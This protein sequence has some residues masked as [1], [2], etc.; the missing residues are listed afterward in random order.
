[1]SNCSLYLLLIIYY[2]FM[3]TLGIKFEVAGVKEAQAGLTSLKNSLNQ[4]LAQN[5][6]AVDKS[7]K[8]A[9]G[10]VTTKS[11]ATKR[12]SNP[13]PIPSER[14]EV[15]YDYVQNY[16]RTLAY[17]KNKQYGAATDSFLR[18]RFNAVAGGYF[19]GIGSAGANRTF[20]SLENVLR[21]L[22]GKEEYA[23]TIKLADETINKLN[24]FEQQNQSA[25]P[26]FKKQTQ[27]DINAGVK[28]KLAGSG[29]LSTIFD[30]IKIPIKTLQYSFYEGI[31]SNFGNRFAEGL[32]KAFNEDLDLSF[33]RKG[34]VSGKAIS[35]TATSGLD[36]FNQNA[37]QVGD[38]YNNLRYAVEDGQIVEVG[39]KF[40]TLFKSIVKSVTGIGDSYV[41]GFRKSSVQLEA[42]R[43]IEAQIQ[44]E[45][46]SAGDLTGKTKVIY[47]VGGFAADKGQ[48]GKKIA[49]DLK[50]LVN[51]Q[52]E[53][54][55]ADNA[56][57]D[58]TASAENNQ[59]LWGLNALANTT[60]INL[61]GFNPDA[62]KLAAKVIN[63]LA[64]NPKIK[65]DLV[66]HSAGGFVVEEAQ[67]ILNL[68][69]KGD[70]VKA[71]TVGTPNVKGGIQADG[72]TRIMGEKDP[73]LEVEKAGEHLGITDNTSVVAKGVKNHQ[74][75][76]YLKSDDFVQQ[77]LG[78]SLDK[79]KLKAQKK[80][81][82]PFKGKLIELESLHTKY[83]S[84]IYQ[85]LDELGDELSI[86]PDRLIAKNR[87]AKLRDRGG[88]E[89]NRKL[90]DG[91]FKP[92]NLKE[93]TETAVLVTG[94][95]SGAK[96]RSGAKF[97]K[98]LN[99]LV[100]DGGKTQYVGV[101][102]PFTDVLDAEDVRNPD[103][104]KSMP[105]ILDM[106]AQ[107][108]ELGYNPDA[109]EIA[110]Q[111]MD[112][113]AKN[114]QLKV[115]VAG[116]SGGGYVAEDV[117]ELLKS[118]GADMKR[119][120]VMGVG[121][122]QLPG[123]VKNK[124][125]RKVMGKQ[126]PV[127]MARQLKQLNNKVKE[128]IGFD[129][130]PELMTKLQNIEGIDTHDLDAYVANSK[131][132]QDFFY[133]H[134][135]DS[136]ELID[137]YAE[138]NLLKNQTNDVSQAMGGISEDDTLDS[139]QKLEKLHN[140]K[141]QYINLLR[142]IHT[143]AKYSQGIG[144]G[145][146]F[147]TEREVSALELEDA[148]VIVDPIR[149]SVNNE[150]QND[151]WKNADAEESKVINNRSK[152]LAQEYKQY[153][154]SLSKKTTSDRNI[155]SQ[156]VARDFASSDPS[157]QK[158]L[159]T[160][161]KQNFSAKAK[162]YRAAVKSGQLELAK[163]Q[164]EELI[165]LAA[166]IKSL[167]GELSQFDQL[168][169]EIQSNF[170]AY[171]SY[172]GSVE[173]EVL[174]GGGG[175]GRINQGLPDLFEQQLNL[176]AEDGEN[177][178]LGFIDGILD[179]LM[180]ARQAGEQLID[181]VEEGIRDA[182]EIQSP[183]KLAKRLG[184]WFAQ[185]FGLGL[186]AEDLEA[187]GREVVRQAATGIEGE[188]LIEL[189][190]PVNLENQN[191][192]NKI[193]SGLAGLIAK[194]PILD[195]Y[196]NQ[197]ATIAG[198]LLGGLGIA[199][200]VRSLGQFGRQSLDTAMAV[201]SLN[202]AIMF[203]S[204]DFAT[205]ADN[206]NYVSQTAKELSIDLNA[207]KQ[208]YAGLLGAAKGTPLE[209]AQTERIFAAFA[210]TAANRGV[211]AQGQ[212]R[213]FTAL[214]Q[215][216]GKRKLQAEEV[217][218]QIGDIKGFGDFQNL[219]AQALGVSTPQLTIMMEQG[220]VGIDVLPKIAALLEAQNAAADGTQTALQAQ[221]KY[222]NSLIEFQTALGKLLQPLQKLSFNV[223]SQGLDFLT[224]K[225]GGLSKI[226]AT[227]TGV[228]AVALFGQVNLLAVAFTAL[229][230]I[231]NGLIVIFSRLWA[232]KAVIA[233]NLLK[234]AA[235]YLLVSA[236][237][238]SVTNAI[239]LSKNQYQDLNDDVEKLTAGMNRYREAV[240]AATGEQKEFGGNK[241][242]EPKL[243]EG[244]RLPD[245]LAKITGSERLNFDIVRNGLGL[246]T[247][248]ERRQAD[249]QVAAGDLNF[250]TNQLLMEDAPALG[251]AK[252]IAEFDRQIAEIQSRRLEL[253]PSDKKAL[254]AS[255][256]EERKL[257]T[258]RDKQLKVLTEYQQQLQAADVTNKKAL[259]DL[260][261]G[262]GRG[263]FTTD[264]YES[265]KAGLLDTQSAT[266]EKL[267]KI[268]D[269]LSN[270]TK[271][272]SEFQRE[273]RNSN[274]RINNFIERRGREA[275]K[276]RTEIITEGVELKKGD[277]VIQL[278]LDAASRSEL[279]DYVVELSK[280]I[281]Q[282]QKRLNSGALAE[283]YRLVQQ[284]AS[285]NNLSLDSTTVD[286]ML[287]EE[288]RSQ[289]EKDALGEVKSLLDNQSRLT[290]Y[291]EQIAQNIQS[292]RNA[293]ID[294]NRTISD[295]FFRLTQQI[296]EATIETERLI[297]QIFYTDIK[298]KL[299]AA[300]APGSNTFVNGIIDNVQTIIDSAGQVAQKIFGDR[301][302][303][304][305]FES[306]TR[307]LETEMRDFVK[308]VN[309]ASDALEDF[310]NKLTGTSV[311]GS[312]S[313]DNI[314]A[315]R[316]A[317]I[318]KESGTNFKAVNPHS[319]ALGYGQVMPANIK[320][321]TKE[322]LGK[323]LT[324]QQ[325]LNDSLAQVEVINYK[326]NQY[327]QKELSQGLDLDTA[328]R[329]VA[330]TWYSGQP[331]LYNNTKPQSYN[332]GK[333]P[334]I[335]SYTKDI[336]SRFK[337]EGGVS[338]AATLEYEASYGRLF[339]K[340]SGV[341]GGKLPTENATDSKRAATQS[342][343]NLLAVPNAPSFSTTGLLPA[344]PNIEAAAV[345]LNQELVGVKK[346]NLELSKQETEQLRESLLTET[347][348]KI[349]LN[350]RQGKEGRQAS[351]AAVLG[352]EDKVFGFKNS[353]GFPSATAELT[354]SLRSLK[355]QFIDADLD[356]A[357]QITNTEDAITSITNSIPVLID[358]IAKFKAIGTPEALNAAQVQQSA[359][360][361]LTK[362]LPTLQSNLEKIKA[363]QSE[364][365]G[366]EEKSA[367]YLRDQGIFKIE[368]EGLTK[369]NTIL[370]QKATL[371]ESRGT[372]EQQ[373]QLKLKQEEQRLELA[374]KDI[375]L[376]LPE[377]MQRNEEIL[378]EQRQSKVNKEN[379]NYDSQLEE[380]DIERKLLDY[381]D[382][383]GS[384]KAGFMS[385]FGLDFGAEKL[386][387]E[388][389][390]DQE[391][392]RFERELVELEKQ[393]Q[394]DPEKLN[395]LTQ[396]A[397]ELNAVNLISI[398]SEFKS[399]G[400]TVED[401]FGTATQGFFTQFT[402]NLFDGKAQSDRALLEERLRYAEEVV[403]L[404]NNNRDTPG[405]LAHLKNRA[406]ELNE[407]KLDKIR[408]EFNLFSRTI[409]LAKGALLEFV[410]Q[411]A[412]LAAQ[413]AASKFISSILE[414][415]LPAL[416]GGGKNFDGVK[417]NKK[418]K[419]KA[420][421]ADRGITVGDEIGN[422]NRGGSIKQRKLSDRLT[423]ILKRNA[424][425]VK[426]AWQSEGKD[427]QLGVFHTGE[428]LL[429]RKTGEAGRYQALKYKLG[430]NP[431]AKIAN[432]AGG[433]TIPEVGSTIL[434]SIPKSR[435]G[436][437]LSALNNRG[438]ATATASKTI[439]IK[440]TVVTPNADSFRLNQDQLNQDLIERLRRGI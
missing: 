137:N 270:V 409:D 220:E 301:A 158:E 222:N 289:G 252:E 165:R 238:A 173:T 69:G 178:A 227:L 419:V 75:T 153:L 342:A 205:G 321:W 61:K 181:E 398:Q 240:K 96:G 85:D 114:A 95:F 103:A 161:I 8:N 207:A 358:Q 293:L 291:Q 31:G 356:I 78:D 156:V 244:V 170:K 323:S 401:Y 440:T 374:I 253:L 347:R 105:K 236:A 152:A 129:I 377:G 45:E 327:L 145:E 396:A 67:E 268:N 14:G 3:K 322:A 57:T 352:V 402:T 77:L 217:K 223:L 247:E 171:R 132:V 283:G 162:A 9:T 431:L 167:Y 138:I 50:P 125:F 260:E 121:T 101:R 296:K 225:F 163:Q 366:L 360:D 259:E 330:S 271:T 55:G 354:N 196:K 4:S 144:G 249:F 425:G 215:I 107:T 53:V 154:Q 303:E 376:K 51:D 112:L 149:V 27:R 23:Q 151:P 63:T 407:E 299:Q 439:N 411:L 388:S 56:F 115:K 272:L 29:I 211:D 404:E 304:L 341:N 357:S 146:F 126:D 71:K 2:L 209:G 90:R 39:K 157:K 241:V 384:K 52:T 26:T 186:T 113:L 60:K 432:Y 306:E 1:M 310:A 184:R 182:G 335:D 264:A 332:G 287:A 336:L 194:Y 93:G 364:I 393:Y 198:L 280:T 35:Y 200:I 100:D 381:Q 197:I 278:E 410:K 6:Q 413:Q 367:Y 74:F 15:L 202:K 334:S 231:L 313:T 389:A 49:G 424:P 199:A 66:G 295:Y 160:F 62:V 48:R 239:K 84:T 87:K 362:T 169:P 434:S 414:T 120:E 326:L 320:S 408:G 122:P 104:T 325:F 275:Q 292:N 193:K 33:E 266:A 318:G 226:M 416:G 147:E 37:S 140:I 333:Y 273:L 203:S 382:Q 212:E 363:L 284:S 176:S 312:S 148:G 216:I 82:S 232:A 208:A 350:R 331:G 228:A 116:Y 338:T 65:V 309:G 41:R 290:G 155:F 92:I 59:V 98:Q 124:E 297:S 12:T 195:K 17:A 403:G 83:L 359:L 150:D 308:E 5:K 375:Q 64:K 235:V 421:K 316:R 427:A 433:G 70:R 246:T 24:N 133:G 386:K 30:Q 355:Q 344:P 399:L 412:Q 328:V 346:E 251:A 189:E 353:F 18:P 32:N 25:S 282:S 257:S 373:R 128:I 21:K 422:Y 233:V 214:G 131:E 319:G 314:T 79:D 127:M 340:Q 188:E 192:F 102:N 118:Q 179:S 387:K 418:P 406:R 255:L 263:E 298:G 94:G 20:D 302:A 368:Q 73:F 16:Q 426:S 44:A 36:Q 437:D 248:A 108:H 394:G 58:V 279:N 286:R 361:E 237:I 191:I 183:S 106:F 428:E 369:A 185:G 134:I 210:Q 177:V 258:E 400:K 435:N 230:K 345:Q 168:E 294:F 234:F 288:E 285:D 139:A 10:R 391:K 174:T 337:N 390:I 417:L 305:G 81:R 72:V 243:N 180:D 351:D 392:L 141:E 378:G 436:I 254:E 245:W 206:L 385:R 172:I 28:P 371:A 221:T 97:A 438:T 54:I 7:L 164:G 175:R 86:A 339:T 269:I 143:L 274:E 76:D 267:E 281:E 311:D 348:N 242:A 430:I 109:T 91:N 11:T 261:L 88:K 224:Q 142:Q 80:K 250:R 136:R 317:I 307:T 420:F 218:G 47:T 123:G 34:E 423:Q 159:L 13:I 379:I 329:R 213:L 46:N 265:S 405:K 300:L 262:Y 415:V 99:E 343:P 372:L 256:E 22:V 135:P 130:F 43:K 383:I 365:P 277:R 219:I 229:G 315:L 110:A 204:R 38:N 68:L 40:D 19:D 119:V 187:R 111:V 89:V 276:E 349:E 397:R 324:P 395:R 429:S 201:E 166:S 380:L 190:V 42:L 117:I 370:T